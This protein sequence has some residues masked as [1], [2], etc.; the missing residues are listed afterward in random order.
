[1]HRKS[2]EELF[3]EKSSVISVIEM[4]CCRRIVELSQAVVKAAY[5]CHYLHH[6]SRK[7]RQERCTINFF[8]LTA[9]CDK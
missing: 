9:L 7:K 5:Y 6:P 2:W 3:K 1:M 8:L 4:V